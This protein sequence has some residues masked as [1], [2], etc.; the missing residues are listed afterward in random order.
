MAEAAVPADDERVVRRLYEVDLGSR[1][2]C[3]VERNADGS[4]PAGDEL[5]DRL[6]QEPL[7]GLLQSKPL[8]EAEHV[9]LV[10]LEDEHG[11]DVP[12]PES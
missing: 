10:G 12:L 3:S 6:A 8:I 9:A 5:I 2:Q 4:W 1:W 11:R 7:E